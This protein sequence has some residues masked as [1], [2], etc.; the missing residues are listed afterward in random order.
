MK[1]LKLGICIIGIALISSSCELL[2]PQPKSP[3][4][5]KATTIGDISILPEPLN[6]EAG[7]SSFIIFDAL[8]VLSNPDQEKNQT[9]LI[10]GLEERIGFAPELIE[11]NRDY[12]IT[13]SVA[14]LSKEEV[15]MVDTTNEALLNEAYILEI[16]EKNILLKAATDE[17][18][19]RGIQS[20]L[21]LV[22][23]QSMTEGEEEVY[24][25]PT[26]KI[27]DLPQMEIRSAMLDVARHFFSVDEVKRY[28]NQ[29]ALYKFNTF[30]MHLTDD[31]GWRVEMKNWPALT[32][33]G[34]ATEVGGGAGGF[35]TQEEF[36]ELIN[37]AADRHI[38]I[39][40][41]IDMPGH[42]NAAIVSYPQLNGNGK[43]PEV[44]TGTNVG[45]STFDA[46]NEEVYAFLDDIL[47][48]F[49]AISPSKYIH[50]GG[51]ESHV[52]KK[53][54]YIKFVERVEALVRK[55]G[56]VAVGWDE[57]TQADISGPAV[58]QL[59]N[60]E[61]NALVGIEKGMPI[62][63]SPAKKAYLD[64]KYNEDSE[65]GLNWAAYIELED[66]YNWNPSTY[67]SDLDPSVILGLEAPLWSE[68]IYDSASL[69]YLAFPRAI[70]YAEL[71]WTQSDKYNWER[72]KTKLKSHGS[73]LEKQE[74]NFYRSTEIDW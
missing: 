10:S 57:I 19:F 50:I 64:M 66:A 46:N 44:Y 41:E 23:N 68:T 39:I 22:P 4:E 53:K 62:L 29:L 26:V 21:Q 55:H 37:Y 43:T 56:K 74:I 30:H 25:L 52:T 13:L 42:T 70:A 58:V 32:E 5:A 20:L 73:W 31:Q 12:Q 6:T 15:W 51:D 72:F 54:D 9:A 71:A 14:P 36:T 48:Q 8:S 11:N 67:F 27:V 40:P 35:Y 34:A 61:E 60:N 38:E 7:G 47:G 24:V 1:I 17:G 45:F 59:W 63:L 33:I 65:F 2:N 16:S 3:V 69:E 18:L 49:A 28:I